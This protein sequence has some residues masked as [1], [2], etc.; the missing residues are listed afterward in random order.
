ML[1]SIYTPQFHAWMVSALGVALSIDKIIKR[2]PLSKRKLRTVTSE[3][4]YCKPL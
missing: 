2:Y 3:H 1:K 4:M